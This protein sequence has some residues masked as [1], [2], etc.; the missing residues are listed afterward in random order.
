MV[1]NYI[2]ASLDMYRR[3]IIEAAAL[4]SIA[5]RLPNRSS[6]FAPRYPTRDVVIVTYFLYAEQSE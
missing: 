6:D 3:G 2:D 4:R 1:D 5:G